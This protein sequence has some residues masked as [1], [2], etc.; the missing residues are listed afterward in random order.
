M[1]RNSNNNDLNVIVNGSPIER[2][3]FWNNTA[4][5][6]KR[7]SEILKATLHKAFED[8][9]EIVKKELP[10]IRAKA[11]A[12]ARN[13]TLPDPLADILLAKET[14][15]DSGNAENLLM[16][17]R[18]SSDEIAS[19]VK[20]HIQ[21][22]KAS[23][24][25]NYTVQ[26]GDSL[27][28]LAKKFNTTVDELARLNNIDDANRGNIYAGERLHVP[29]KVEETD[30]L[31]EGNIINPFPK[32]MYYIR[33]NEKGETEIKWQDSNKMWYVDE[34]GVTWQHYSAGL[35][36]SV[37][38]IG[39]KSVYERKQKKLERAAR[40]EYYK[41]LRKGES[42]DRQFTLWA[43][44]L[45]YNERIV[46]EKTDPYLKGLA[47]FVP[48]VGLVNSVK[49]LATGSDIYENKADGLDYGLSIVDVATS[50]ISGL[51]KLPKVAKT[52]NTTTKTV[53]TTT[54]RSATGMSAGKT[55]FTE[56]T[57]EEE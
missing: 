35:K 7:D 33:T 56:I 10:E 13:T 20:P 50:G 39:D 17:Y 49:T 3:I 22:R 9:L 2:I 54:D 36:D 18:S 16:G 38:V 53:N 15:V 5:D 52:V 26:R 42:W 21:K 31:R 55:I 27:S 30:F 12:S 47:L 8:A 51:F 24:T 14:L 34:N 41:N 25:G 48:S 4:K 40:R 29:E 44:G 28:S 32:G 43:R 11:M 6:P 45:G 46:R 1:A 23:K 19:L 37:E 57:K